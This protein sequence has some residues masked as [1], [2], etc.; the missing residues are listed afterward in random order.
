MPLL[1]P[2]RALALVVE[3]TPAGMVR[4]VSCEAALGLV[5]AEDVASDRDYPPFAR[6]MMDG[7]AVRVADA[8]RRVCVGGMVAAGQDPQALGIEVAS[9]R[10]AEVATGA[11][12]PAGT[13]AVVMHEDVERDGQTIQLPQRIEAG[14]HIA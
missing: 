8:G 12:C 1:D 13:E 9:G 7:Y 11:C 4:E 5:L 6:A 14:Q 2:E 3:H 10:P